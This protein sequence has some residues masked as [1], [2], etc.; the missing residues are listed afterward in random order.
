MV[1]RENIAT[2]GLYALKEE[3]EAVHAQHVT[4]DVSASQLGCVYNNYDISY[5]GEKLVET[6]TVTFDSQNGTDPRRV[7]VVQGQAVSK[8][9]DPVSSTGQPFGGWYRQGEEQPWNF[10]TPVT[11]DMTLYA[12]WPSIYTYALVCESPAERPV[13]DKHSARDNNR[14][15][16]EQQFITEV[17]QPS[18]R[19]DSASRSALRDLRYSLV[20]SRGLAAVDFS[21][22]G[23][24]AVTVQA[25]F[26]DSTGTR[27][28]REQAV[29]VRVG[30][31]VPPVI[32]VG[33]ADFTLPTGATLGSQTELL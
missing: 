24:Y 25:E 28:K 31:T 30:D 29:A 4:G 33:V 21:T 18:I 6:C 12:K 7:V 22:I 17:L 20:N 9:A 19:V 27:Q 2:N 14:F 23:T 10:L 8:P 26:I 5:L 32:Q 11:E 1:F 16:G 15:A 13:N 3:H